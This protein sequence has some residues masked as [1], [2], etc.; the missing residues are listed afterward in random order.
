V[1]YYEGKLTRLGNSVSNGSITVYSHIEIGDEVIKKVAINNN[2]DGFLREGLKGSGLV[3]IWT[4]KNSMTVKGVAALQ[5]GDGKKYASRP[6]ELGFV[7]M[8]FVSLLLGAMM[9]AMI[10]PLYSIPVVAFAFWMLSPVYKYKQVQKLD[11]VEI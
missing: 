11:A 8:P 5:V 9:I 1:G 2:L 4:I 7:A 3:K 6:F 10:D